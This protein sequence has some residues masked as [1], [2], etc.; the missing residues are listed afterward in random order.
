MDSLHHYLRIHGLGDGGGSEVWSLA[1]ER[2]L[3]LF[4]RYGIKATFYCVAEDLEHCTEAT[5]WLKKALELGH[6][7]GNHTWHHPYSL[8]RLSATEIQAEIAQGKQILEQTL[9]CEVLG[10]RA[11]G[12]HTSAVVSDA[13]YASGHRYESSAFPCTPYY[14]AKALVIALMRIRGKKSESILASPRLLLA[15]TQPY[16]ADLKQPYRRVSKQSELHLLHFPISVWCGIPLIGTAFSMLGPVLSGWIMKRASK[17]AWRHNG[18]LTLEFHAIDLLSLHE[19]QLDKRLQ[20]QPDL[21]LTLAHKLKC[22]EAVFLATHRLRC[23][24]L[25]DLLG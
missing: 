20:V 8:T 17:K 1:M 18:H 25:E 15:P 23:V 14:L 13:V 12:Y 7:I 9:G 10:F 19:D 6:A 21:K 24:R 2:F 11:P 16:L 4:D 5:I 3:T 22:F